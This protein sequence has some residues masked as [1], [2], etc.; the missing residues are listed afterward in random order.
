MK[1]GLP[2]L[3]EGAI[4][5]R[6]IAREHEQI[7]CLYARV[8]ST[9]I[10][11]ERAEALASFDRYRDALEAHVSFEEDIYFDTLR[12]LHPGLGTDLARL[13]REHARFRDDLRDVRKRINTGELEAAVAYFDRLATSV[14]DHD[15]REERLFALILGPARGH[16]PR[17]RA[18]RWWARWSQAQ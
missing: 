18:A 8:A 17:R 2:D 1:R 10:Q 7:E 5:A 9:I 16:T 14:A 4:E 6:R 11:G 13:S 3:A 12:Q 15:R